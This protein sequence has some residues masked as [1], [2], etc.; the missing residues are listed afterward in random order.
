MS[1]LEYKSKNTVKICFT[2]NE[3]NCRA[4]TVRL[5]ECRNERRIYERDFTIIG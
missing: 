1:E 4:L 3:E 2:F 5:D